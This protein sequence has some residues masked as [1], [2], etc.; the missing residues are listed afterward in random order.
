MFLHRNT[1]PIA[2]PPPRSTQKALLKN[3]TSAKKE[4]VPY[5]DNPLTLLFKNYFDGH[6][7]V[8]MLVCVSPSLADA[9][10]T[11]H[12][13]RFSAITQQ[14]STVVSQVPDAPKGLYNREWGGGI[15]PPCL[16]SFQFPRADPGQRHRQPHDQ[17]GAAQA[18]WCTRL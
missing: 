16:N 18:A 6:G 11:T 15:T 17:R 3:Q 1:H 9:D 14:V 12:V 2:S 4:R 8:L 13:L 7:K 10:E 5:R